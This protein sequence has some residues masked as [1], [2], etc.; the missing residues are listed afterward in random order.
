MGPKLIGQVGRQQ[1]RIHQQLDEVGSFYRRA[2]G[3]A[4]MPDTGLGRA[5]GPPFCD[6]E[7]H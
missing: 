5:E 6:V 4:E 3:N 1:V 7:L 2:I